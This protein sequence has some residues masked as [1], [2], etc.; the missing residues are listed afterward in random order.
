MVD[1]LFGEF[2]VF[3]FE[4]VM[5]EFDYVCVYVVIFYYKVVELFVKD[6]DFNFSFVI[7]MVV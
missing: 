1:G 2:G 4:C 3:V 7:K 6:L 5:V